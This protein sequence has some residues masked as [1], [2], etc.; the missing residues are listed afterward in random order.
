[1]IPYLLRQLAHPLP[2]GLV[3]DLVLHCHREEDGLGEDACLGKV[4][5]LML[6]GLR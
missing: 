1:M 6:A 2:V 3:S 4:R 5:L